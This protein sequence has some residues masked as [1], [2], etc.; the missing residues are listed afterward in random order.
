M[1]STDS[2]DE[3]QERNIR[4]QVR[5]DE[6]NEEDLIPNLSDVASEKSHVHVEEEE[7]AAPTAP[8]HPMVAFVFKTL[9]TLLLPF[10]KIFFAPAAQ[11]TFVKTTVMIFTISCIIATSMFAYIV[12]YNQYVPPITHIQPIWFQYGLAPS[13]TNAAA[14][15]NLV[16]GPKATVNIAGGNSVVQ[17]LAL[18]GISWIMQLMPFSLLYI[19]SKT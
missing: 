17:Y 7:A 11:K 10:C 9:K 8:P 18:G 4:R 19:A 13:P 1:P 6:E 2:N 5:N 16:L 15:Q 3:E 14:L 12:F